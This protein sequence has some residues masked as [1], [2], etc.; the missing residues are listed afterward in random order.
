MGE[1][2]KS[3]SIGAGTEASYRT[4]FPQENRVDQ[5][6]LPQ[7]TSKPRYT[8]CFNGFPVKPVQN[9]RDRSKLEAI[10]LVRHPLFYGKENSVYRR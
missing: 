1:R 9:G 2:A 6:A 10:L 4:C 3:M 5:L 7:Q 8:A